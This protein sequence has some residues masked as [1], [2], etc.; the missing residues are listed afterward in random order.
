MPLPLEYNLPKTQNPSEFEDMVCDICIRR[1][2]RGFQ[3]YGRLGQKQSG[4]DIISTGQEKLI[5]VQCKNYALSV[6]EVEQIIEKAKSFKQPI[7]ELIIAIGS[8]RDVKLQEHII[9]INQGDKEKPNFTISTLFW[10]EISMI[11]SENKDLLVKYY[12]A[13]NE[14]SIEWLVGEF[15]HLINQYQI[16]DYVKEDPTIGIPK[17]YPELVDLFVCEIRQVLSRENSMQQHPRFA[18][19]NYFADTLYDYSGYLGTKLFWA[20]TMYT[21]QNPYDLEDIS[22]KDS[23]IVKRIKQYKM[24]LERWYGKVNPNCSMFFVGYTGL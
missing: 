15:N 21:M 18:A 10:E 13:L 3:R 11:I 14:S 12:P 16:L 24:E 1:Y 17:D 22:S 4:I 20:N 7:A 23:K 6:K 8:S 19:M 5:C 2:G 9:M